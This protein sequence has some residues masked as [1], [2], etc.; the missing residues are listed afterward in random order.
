MTVGRIT[1]LSCPM[2]NTSKNQI[3]ANTLEFQQALKW[4][5][6]H[7]LERHLSDVRKIEKDLEKLS[8]VELP[9]L[10]YGLWVEVK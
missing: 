6:T 8:N 4:L 5:L 10:P 3:V 9:D 2:C 1:Q 7:E